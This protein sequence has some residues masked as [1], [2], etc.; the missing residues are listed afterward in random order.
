MFRKSVGLG[1][2]MAA[3]AAM[4][5]SMIAPASAFSTAVE[6]LGKSNGEMTFTLRSTPRSLQ[7]LASRGGAH[8]SADDAGLILSSSL[9]I[10]SNDGSDGGAR[11]AHLALDVGRDRA[12][13]LRSLNDRLFVRADV[14]SLL[15]M[16]G[17]D[18]EV[19]GWLAQLGRLPGFGFVGPAVD[20]QWLAFDG[21]DTLAG[22]LSRSFALARRPDRA[23]KGFATA[24]GSRASVE[25]VG[26]SEAGTHL[27][28]SVPVQAIYAQLVAVAGDLAASLPVGMEFPPA[29]QV[30]N[31]DLYLDAW[32]RDGRFTMLEFDL[33]QLLE[34]TG[35][36][37]PVT[38]GPLVLRM[39]VA[40]SAP[41]VRA[42]REAIP[43]AP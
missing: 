3:I 23:V 9:S 30:G 6:A 28:V 7:E 38:T 11:R 37:G 17:A 32:I 27:L 19:A 34:L 29:A 5:I 20:G 15:R 2:A 8:L 31:G 16:F 43:V 10:S 14:R 18:P 12:V 22:H 4:V 26:Q 35:E 39:T 40:A 42:P 25:T 13:E 24:L 36:R 1:L 33:E 41:S 21:A